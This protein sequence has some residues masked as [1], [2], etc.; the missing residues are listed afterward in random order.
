MSRKEC[1]NMPKTKPACSG[2]F[3]RDVL[4]YQAIVGCSITAAADHFGVS[5]NS[6]GAWRRRT[7]TPLGSSPS[8]GAREETEYELT[9]LR[10]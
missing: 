9:R 4:A 6:L 7:E 10:R 3:K 2:Q 1:F 8:V 5:A